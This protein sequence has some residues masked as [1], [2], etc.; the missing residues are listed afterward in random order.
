MYKINNNLKDRLAGL[1]KDKDV[2]KKA[3]INYEF[4]AAEKERKL[5]ETRLKLE[6]TQKS[7]KMLNSGTGK[8]DHILSIGK[9][10]GDHHGLGYTGE[11]FVRHLLN[12]VLSQV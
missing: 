12:L 11:C 4:L 5:Q 10:S 2:L 1:H 8:L 7:F 6:N 9:L 3:M